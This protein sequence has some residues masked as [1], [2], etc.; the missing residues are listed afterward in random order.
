MRSKSREI[1]HDP[2]LGLPGS[3]GFLLPLQDTS[4]TPATAEASVMAT[5]V[6][7]ST[8][9]YAT[10]AQISTLCSIS[11]IL[12]LLRPCLFCLVFPTGCSEASICFTLCP[13][14]P[15]SASEERPVT[16][17]KTHRSSSDR[18]RT[19]SLSLQTLKEGSLH[20]HAFQP[21]PPKTCSPDSAWNRNTDPGKLAP[22]VGSF[23]LCSFSPNN[24]GGP[25]DL[26]VQPCR[27]FSAL[28]PSIPINKVLIQ[29]SC[30]LTRVPHQLLKSPLPLAS[31]SLIYSPYSREFGLMPRS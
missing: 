16:C 31:P 30:S 6:G 13:I 1:S 14:L 29:I 8:T 9:K 2:C 23:F 20:H 28:I 24:P 11:Y 21:P 4:L 17:S 15:P 26:S 25:R 18:S 3:Q 22:N 27:Y 10:P 12:T 5:N 19:K 7:G